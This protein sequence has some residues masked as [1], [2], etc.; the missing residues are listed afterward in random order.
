[1]LKEPNYDY[2]KQNIFNYILSLCSQVN[3]IAFYYINGCKAVLTKQYLN[4]KTNHQ[5]CCLKLDFWFLALWSLT[6]LSTIFRLYSWWTV[7]LVDGTGVPGEN[8][9]PVASH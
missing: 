7:L 9:R 1:M 8:N 2:D 6:P 3:Y 5:L 4:D